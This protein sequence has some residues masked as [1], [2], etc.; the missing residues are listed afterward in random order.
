MPIC[1]GE[2]RA[3]RTSLQSGTHSFPLRSFRLSCHPSLQ[4]RCRCSCCQLSAACSNT[5]PACGAQAVWRCGPCSYVWRR[6]PASATS[7]VGYP[8]WTSQAMDS[9]CACR[10]ACR[11]V[12]ATHR[13]STASG[14]LVGKP[15][16]L[17]VSDKGYTGSGA[18]SQSE[19]A[20]FVNPFS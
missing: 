16:G 10:C 9:P 3:I 19:K 11:C 18:G 4:A 17:G 5:S 2:P 8:G 12:C 6:L 13:E 20:I 14:H 7:S 15:A 1:L